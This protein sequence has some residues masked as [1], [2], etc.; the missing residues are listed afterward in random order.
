MSYRKNDTRFVFWKQFLDFGQNLVVRVVNQ[1]A[2]FILE[3]VDVT[4]GS[5]GNL[6]W[7]VWVFLDLYLIVRFYGVHEFF[8]CFAIRHFEVVGSHGYDVCCHF[9]FSF[10]YADVGVSLFIRWNGRAVCQSIAAFRACV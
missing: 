6:V 10:L 1:V 3:T 8:E 5:K 2:I 4:V 9:C 7:V